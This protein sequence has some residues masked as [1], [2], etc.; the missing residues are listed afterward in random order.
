M[1]SESGKTECVGV[2]VF[3]AREDV[4]A[5]ADRVEERARERGERVWVRPYTCG[6]CGAWHVRIAVPKTYAT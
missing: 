4:K 6:R 3:R 1:E 5:Y 2:R